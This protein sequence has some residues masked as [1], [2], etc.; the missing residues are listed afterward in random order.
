MIT[1]D[2]DLR[3]VSDRPLVSEFKT[4]NH[5]DDGGDMGWVEEGID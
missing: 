1:S 5:A 2:R 3:S 4:S